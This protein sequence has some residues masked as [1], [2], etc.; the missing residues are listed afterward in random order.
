MVKNCKFYQQCKSKAVTVV[1]HSKMFLCKSHF[2]KYI[3]DRVLKTIEENSLIDFND[4]EKILVAISGG[5]DSD[6]L[7]TILKKIFKNRVRMEALYIEVGIKPR[8]YSS[9]SQK[10]AAEL[11]KE[12]DIPFNVVDIKPKYG[13]DIDLIHQL[14]KRMPTSRRKGKRQHFRGDCSYCGLIKRYEINYYAYEHGFT[15]VVTGHNL[16]DEATTLMSNFFN[17]DIELLSRGGPKTITDMEGLVTRIKPLYYIYEQE[18]ILYAYYANVKHLSTECEYATDSPMIK[19]KKSLDN[20]EE[21]KRGNMMNFVRGFQKDLR[22]MLFEAMPEY[23][24]SENKCN[25][26]S[27][28]TYIEKCAFCKTKHRLISQMEKYGLIPPHE[29]KKK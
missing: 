25:E 3:E 9:D 22:M 5:K 20:I 21:F 12:L 11:C 27:M 2:I 14:G 29:E 16:T 7:I 10:V 18:I 6:A 1:P 23:K 19:L 28:P 13:Y 8:D 4:N 17:A 15:K 24:K 26:C